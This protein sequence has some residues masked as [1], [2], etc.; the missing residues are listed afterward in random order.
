MD[1][2]EHTVQTLNPRSN[3]VSILAVV[4]IIIISLWIVFVVFDQIAASI[5]PMLQMKITF[6]KP[7]PIE[8]APL[9][10]KSL[11]SHFSVVSIALWAWLVM[12][13]ISSIGLL[14]RRNWS[15]ILYVA[16]LVIGI[17]WFLLKAL[18]WNALDTL[19]WAGVGKKDVCNGCNL[20]GYLRFESLFSIVYDLVV[21]IVL[22]WIIK[23]L[24][25]QEIRREFAG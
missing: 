3:F 18:Y 2:I 6:N 24:M 14:K 19:V 10:I 13:L 5:L 11:I 16:L 7:L 20:Q 8:H 1:T 23:K 25:S 22:V 9:I 21:I 17:A 12:A 4:S 15:R